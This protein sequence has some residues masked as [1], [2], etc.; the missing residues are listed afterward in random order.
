[1]RGPHVRFC[2]RKEAGKLFSAFTY[3]IIFCESY[4][5]LPPTWHVGG[6]VLYLRMIE[7][8]FVEII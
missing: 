7:S 2:E 6:N 4:R 3:S 1:M 5:T 8:P